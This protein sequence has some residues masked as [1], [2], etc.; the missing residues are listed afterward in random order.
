MTR[1]FGI[2]R[3]SLREA[4]KTPRTKGFIE[5][6]GRKGKYVKSVVDNA[7]RSPIEGMIMVDHK[8]SGSC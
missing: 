7:L 5:S 8:R 6:Q 4:M 3:I 2:S 1:R